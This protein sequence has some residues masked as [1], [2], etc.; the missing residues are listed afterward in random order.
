MSAYLCAP[1]VRVSAPVQ[2]TSNDYARSNSDPGTRLRL[3]VPMMGD[4]YTDFGG[5]VKAEEAQEAKEAEEAN[6]AKK[7]KERVRVQS[8][9]VMRSCL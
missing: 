5:R 6:E 4:N 1:L 3:N 7:A 8:S 2:K 9:L